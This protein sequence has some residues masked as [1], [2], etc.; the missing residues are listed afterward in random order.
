MKITNETRR[1]VMTLA[2][3]KF[4][5]QRKRGDPWRFPACLK[6]AWAWVKG[7]EDREAIQ[8][9]QEAKQMRLA[10]LR[11]RAV[12]PIRGSLL[13]MSHAE[14]MAKMRPRNTWWQGR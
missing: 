5:V 13:N 14:V 9:E 11:A 2:W 8:R 10:N 12:V 6:G 7:A 1:E 4:R 3:R